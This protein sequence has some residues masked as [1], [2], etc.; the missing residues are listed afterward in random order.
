MG[1]DFYGEWDRN[2]RYYQYPNAA[3]FTA[4]KNHKISTEQSDA[5]FF[6]IS[7]QFHPW[8][9]FGEV[10]AMDDAYST[11]AFLVDANGDIQYDNSQ[12]NFYEFVEDNDDQDQFPDWIR[13]GSA[14]DRLIFPG[15]DE[16][17]DFISDFN[18]ND[19]GT[20]NNLI[21]DYEEPFLR[22]AVD[23]PEYL[24]GI[25]LNNNDWI[26]RFEDD[27]LPDYPYKTDRQG[28]N[29]F[30]GAELVPGARLTLGQADEQMIS[31]DR[32]SRVQYALF[33]FDRD[34]PGV[35]RLRVFDALK[36]VA[37]TIPDDRREPTPFV[38]AP[39]IQ[40]LV[41]DILPAQDTWVNSLW[42]GFDYAGIDR[43]NIINKFKYEF[44]RQNQDEPRDIDGRRLRTNTNFF[45][46]INK[47]D[48]T[49]DLGRFSL[50]PKFKSEYLRRTPFL[51]QEDERKEWT[52][53][54][55]LLARLPVLKHTVLMGG[56]EQLL[57]RDLMSDE[58]A[59]VASGITM[60]T[61]DLSS[62]NVAVQLSNSSDYMG[63]RLTTQL[64]LRYGR[65]QTEL[66]LENDSGFAK[67]SESSNSTTS[68][69]TV[70]AGIQ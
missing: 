47:F 22:Y 69:I 34:V 1:L 25:D 56:V 55:V 58:D 35:G 66:V 38:D 51:V 49:Y 50:Q 29:V 57:L 28:Y 33:T 4:G 3:L 2:K 65:T 30:A 45:G 15:W 63:Y 18:Q 23:R 59:M 10:Y 37:D 9:F 27:D 14:N 40:P 17:N 39:P 41:P 7:R 13:A 44:Y 70:Y 54:F 46:L 52:G 6:N 67:G 62:V 11:T 8:F 16:N 64:G 68:F 60:E 24:F 31:A 32:S 61:G 43:L 5:W 48:Y 20:V 26:D 19:N 12:R 53:S 42:L 21:P 36:K